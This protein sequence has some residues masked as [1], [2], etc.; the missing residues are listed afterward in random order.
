MRAVK[1]SNKDPNFFVVMRSTGITFYRID[2]ETE[3]VEGVVAK[4]SK[5]REYNNFIFSPDGNYL[6]GCSKNGDIA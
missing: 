2:R 6:F 4:T 3:T 5:V 1:F